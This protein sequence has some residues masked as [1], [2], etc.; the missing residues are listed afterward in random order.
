MN[1]CGPPRWVLVK[2]PEM[3]RNEQPV[4]LALA[5]SPRRAADR[6]ARSTGTIRFGSTTRFPWR[7]TTA[8]PSCRRPCPFD[9]AKPRVGDRL[10]RKPFSTPSDTSVARCADHALVVEAVEAVEVDAAQPRQR[11]IVV[12]RDERRHDRLADLLGER[13]PFLLV[14][15][16]VPLDAV[17]EDLVEE[18]ARGAPLQDRRPDVR[19]GERRLPQ[20][21]QVGDDRV[22]GLV[23]LGAAAQAVERWRRRRSRSAPAPCRRRRARS[24]PGRRARSCGPSARSCL[25][26]L[27]SQRVRLDACSVTPESRMSAWPRKRADSWRI[28]CSQAGTSIASAAGAPR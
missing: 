13:L 28:F 3:S 2:P 1:A 24:P 8:R 10:S 23:H 7:D 6:A 26:E 25:R 14:L 9:C 15:L 11:R 19:I 27:T 18:H 22:G 12:H 4:Q 21:P 20:R 17:A 5:A 16:A